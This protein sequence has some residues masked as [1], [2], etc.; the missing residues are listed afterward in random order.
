MKRFKGFPEGKTRYTG[1]PVIFF[2]QLLAY[3]DDL[4]ELKIV[5]YFFYRLDQMESRFRFLRLVDITSDA[6]FMQVLGED[7]NESRQALAPAL[8]KAV[9]HSILLVA[10][11]AMEDHS[12]MLYFINTPRGRAA[13]KAIARGEW[14]PALE[15]ALPVEVRPE[16]PNIYRLYEENIGPLTP[17]IADALRDAEESFPA[18]WIEEAVRIA[19][20]NNARSWRYINVILN[21]WQAEGRDERKNRQDSEE[22]RWKY[23]KGEYGDYVE[24]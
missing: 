21:R 13:V 14:R 19:V 5:L 3:I 12:E 16:P 7:E 10:T 6:G 1:I 24:H 11:V 4:A 17:I 8:Q 23:I 18:A 9:G 2:E 22:D 15:N 20:E